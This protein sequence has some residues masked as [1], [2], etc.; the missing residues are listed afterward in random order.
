MLW[1]PKKNSGSF[2]VIT[3]TRKAALADGDIAPIEASLS[4]GSASW[5]DAK[6]K[7]AAVDS[8][9]EAPSNAIRPAILAALDTDIGLDILDRAIT[10]FLS[11]VQCRNPNGKMLVVV[12]NI[13]KA[14]ET[15]RRL[16]HVYGLDAQ[17]AASDDS[18]QAKNAIRAFRFDPKARIIIIIAMGY[19]GLDCPSA[20]HIACLTRIR[21]KPWLEQLFARVTRI[22]KKLPS[23]FEQKGYIFGPDDKLMRQAIERIRSEQDAVIRE[24]DD[25]VV[26]ES[27][28]GAVSA[29][30][31][32][33]P[34][35][36]KTSLVN[37]FDFDTGRSTE[38]EA[39]RDV[40][41][42]SGLSVADQQLASIRDQ[43]RPSANTFTIPITEAAK[44]RAMRKKI[45]EMARRFAFDAGYGPEEINA[46]LKKRF[47]KSR[48][49]MT[50]AELTAVFEFLAKQIE[51]RQAIDMEG[52]DD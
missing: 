40:L 5:L 19:E 29:S 11:Y 14:R 48:A 46:A 44:M 18:A 21:S 52:S 27:S 17:V 12:R 51:A 9:A 3:R 13:V 24:R 38:L 6:G 2:K 37:V 33:V 47:G 25:A 26:Q 34:L 43:L 10:A 32:I 42:E 50:L 49:D 39:L 35:S 45:E 31:Q 41:E 1:T 8:L 36:S 7:N 20:T 22:D 15:Q 23:D 4:D 30:G 28:S 16:S